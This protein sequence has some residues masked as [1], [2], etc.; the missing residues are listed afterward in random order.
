MK[1]RTLKEK[2]RRAA[3]RKKVQATA[4]K[5]AKIAAAKAAARKKIKA[6]EER[7]AEAEAE[8]K[9]RVITRKKIK[10]AEER[11]AEA[12]AERKVKA[13]V[14]KKVRGKSK[15]VRILITSTQYPYYGGAATNAYA[16]I[17]YF[18]AA[19]YR[20]AGVFHDGTKNSVDPDKIG[21][22]IRHKSN[23]ATLAHVRAALGGDPDV[24][25]AKNYAAPLLARQLYP[26]TTL[27]YLVSGSPHMMKLSSRGISANRYLASKE[28]EIFK[29][30][31]KAFAV[32]DFVI[33]NSAIGRRL[34]VKHY[35]NSSKILRPIDTSLARN[36][37]G[38]NI[39]FLKRKYSIAFLCSKMSR[40]VKN[41]Y[42]AKRIFAKS[43]ARNKVA[44][45]RGS[46]LFADVK[47]TI[48]L[49]SMPHDKLIQIL[50]NTKLVICTSYYDASPNIIRE[51]LDCGANILVSKNCGGS[52]LY[53]VDFV[54]EDVYNEDEWSKKA[55]L[56]IRK[57]VNFCSKEDK[58]R[59]KS[60]L[61]GLMEVF[62]G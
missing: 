30:E 21:G 36:I 54:C 50:S 12:E 5:K 22:V 34:L 49:P 51:A 8:R 58:A 4:E 35:G 9:V 19:G 33:P 39:P 44:I 10:A 18:R 52:E 13:E 55:S 14:I 6:A 1:V 47:N 27:A 11:K 57:N 7:K 59:D 25:L 17:K 42:L 53:P 46:G 23:K 61:L 62:H 37:V 56:L 38:E 43:R 31:K 60:I 20:T 3:A 28:I 16:L 45:G 15:K 2:R 41:A 24:I 32:A 29:Q 40:S 48:C 26:K